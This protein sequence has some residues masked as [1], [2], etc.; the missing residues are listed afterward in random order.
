MKKWMRIL[1]LAFMLTLFNAALAESGSVSIRIHDGDTNASG[2]ILEIYRIGEAKTENANRAFEINASFSGSGETLSSLS[3]KA[4][5][6]KLAEYARA[7]GIPALEEVETDENG[8]AKFEGLEEGA[9]LICQAGFSQESGFTQI[10]PFIVTVP[11]SV[12]GQWSYQVKAEPKIEP[13]PTVSP[14]PKPTEP[15]QEPNLP[16]TGPMRGPIL[17]LGMGGAALFALGWALCLAKRKKG[18]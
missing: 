18:A 10:E 2:A 16:Q 3:D 17:A 14:T 11:L 4:L 5:P 7:N 8:L 13:I 1:A 9:Y 6:A 12:D 15:P